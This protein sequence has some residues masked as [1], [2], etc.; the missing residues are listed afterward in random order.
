MLE[1][2]E[3]ILINTHIPV[4]KAKQKYVKCLQVDV[5]SEKWE[6]IYSLP[7][8]CIANNEVKELQFKILH[9]YI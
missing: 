6:L 3:V 7:H 8:L 4:S 9:R 5:E 1:Y 2:S